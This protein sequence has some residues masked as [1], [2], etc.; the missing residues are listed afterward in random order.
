M[1]SIDRGVLDTCFRGY[2]GG[3]WALPGTAFRAHSG[4]W[5]RRVA[6]RRAGDWRMDVRQKTLL[7]FPEPVAISPPPGSASGL[8]ALNW[9]WN[10]WNDTIER[11]PR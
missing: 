5:F 10:D 11:R 6:R 9:M 3:V 4:A 8:L 2:D 1:E 7:T